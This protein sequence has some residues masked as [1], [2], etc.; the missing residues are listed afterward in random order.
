MGAMTGHALARRLLELPDH[1]VMTIDSESV[2][3]AYASTYDTDAETDL[4]CV[5]LETEEF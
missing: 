5:T 1:P 4:P 3:E 2:T